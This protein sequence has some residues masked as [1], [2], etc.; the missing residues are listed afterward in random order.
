MQSS[1]LVTIIT[2][3]YN[4]EKHIEQTIQSVIG[5]TY[6]NIEYIVVDGGSKDRTI[7]IIKKYENNISRWI[8]EKDKGI[9]DAF[10]KGILMAKGEIIGIINADDWYEPNAVEISVKNITNADISYGNIQY[11][12]DEKK[13]YLF[14]ANHELLIKE[15]SINHPTVFVKKYLYNSYGLFNTDLKCAMDYELMLRFF[16][17]KVKFIYIP[18]TISNMRLDGVS[19]DKWML[20]VKETLEIKNTHL[21][22]SFRHYVYFIKQSLAIYLSKKLKGSKLESILKF[23]RKRYSKIKKNK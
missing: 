22:K 5:Q 6:K 1:P 2:P 16:K 15:M 9:S 4:G 23:Y 3:V 11:W 18:S 14:T 7:D 17:N 20:G 13:D 10:N 12:K 21:G 8:S 19:D